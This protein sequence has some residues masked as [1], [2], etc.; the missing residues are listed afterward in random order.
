[1]QAALVHSERNVQLEFDMLVPAPDFP[2]VWPV[3]PIVRLLALPTILDG[4][5][6]NAVF[7]TQAVA[8]RGQLHGGHRVEEASGQPPQ[9]AVTQTC[10]GLL[11]DHV[12]PVKVLLLN[13]LLHD[14]I[15][16]KVHYIIGQRTANEEL[17]RKIVDSLGIGA[18]VDFVG[19]NPTLRE[20][21]PDRMSHSLKTLSLSDIRNIDDVVEQQMP[22]IERAL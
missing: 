22:F 1:M 6:E 5:F 13:S 17:H 15:E 9:A 18:V 11:L 8:H 7:I 21:I 16:P 2:W 4:L 10:I 3:Q 20:N 14:G 19:I 12:R